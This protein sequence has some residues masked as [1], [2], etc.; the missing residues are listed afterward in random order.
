MDYRHLWL[1]IGV[2]AYIWALPEPY[3]ALGI[4]MEHIARFTF[5]LLPTLLL[6][7]Y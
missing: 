4:T 6:V 3:T 5:K 7:L 1:E 2:F